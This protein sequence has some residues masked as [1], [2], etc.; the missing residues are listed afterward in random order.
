LGA[1]QVIAWEQA[2]NRVAQA[3][4]LKAQGYRLW[5]LEDVPGQFLV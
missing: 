5:A 1:Q 3:A 2:P 4:A